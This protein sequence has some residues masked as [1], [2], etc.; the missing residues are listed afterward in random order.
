LA[1]YDKKGQ[2]EV[3]IGLM[4]ALGQEEPFFSLRGQDDK[5]IYMSTEQP[6]ISLFRWDSRGVMISIVD[7]AG[8]LD[9]YDSG[10]NVKFSE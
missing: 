6:L 1:F 8:C 7:G 9:L 2:S 10:G 5:G 4:R 3:G